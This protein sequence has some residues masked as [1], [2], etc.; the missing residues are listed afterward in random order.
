MRTMQ[1]GTTSSR[2][3]GLF[4][5]VELAAPLQ[6]GAG[7]H[8][9]LT[10]DCGLRLVDEGADVP[11]SY[12]RLDENPPLAV[13][14]ADLVQ[15]FGKA[16]ARQ[17]TQGYRPQRRA[18]L[19]GKH[20]RKTAEHIEIIPLA[21]G[22]AH[23][24]RIP[25]VYCLLRDHARPASRRVFRPPGRTVQLQL[26]IFGIVAFGSRH[27][28]TRARAPDIERMDAAGEVIDLSVRRKTRLPRRPP[29]RTER[30]WPCTLSLHEKVT[31]SVSFSEDADLAASSRCYGL[32]SHAAG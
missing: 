31:S 22:E 26:S 14:A 12:V 2:R 6:V 30:L 16:E 25:F 28:V 24:D 1:A 19:L 5:I 32:D 21:V 8:P 17:Q 29:L 10:R 20:D 9:N 23:N 18:I 15:P 11:P 27:V 3:H 13:F 4:K 7:G